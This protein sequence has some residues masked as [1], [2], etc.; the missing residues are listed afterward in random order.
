MKNT[1]DPFTF[2]SCVSVEQ[3]QLQLEPSH[4]LRLFLNN[5]FAMFVDNPVKA[6]SNG[7]GEAGGSW[8]PDAYT[9]KPST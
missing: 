3:T 7:E 2:P 1:Q 5:G 4:I 6:S 8:N 9:G